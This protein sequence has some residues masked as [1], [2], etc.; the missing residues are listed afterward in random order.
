TSA[1]L[2]FN[3]KRLETRSNKPRLTQIQLKK[4]F[5]FEPAISSVEDFA[6]DIF[7]FSFLARGMNHTDI[8]Q[9]TPKN[10]INGTI[11]FHRAKTNGATQITIN[12]TMKQIINKYKGK[13]ELGYI[14]PILRKGYN[15]KHCIRLSNRSINSAYRR[16]VKKICI[17]D[18]S[19]YTA[20]H[21]WA[22]LARENN[23][24]IEKISQ[25]LGHSDLTTT[26]AYLSSFGSNEIDEITNKVMELINT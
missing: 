26:K 6:K 13:S 3:I 11:L 16:I 18:F 8:A 10:I 12:S 20:R 23:F 17:P 2:K 14:F 1:F 15:I 9:L 22:N 5:D 4:L 25:G 21:T 24:S 19:F 7:I